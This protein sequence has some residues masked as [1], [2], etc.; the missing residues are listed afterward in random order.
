MLND[1]FFKCHRVLTLWDAC[2]S[3]KK[4]IVCFFFLF[5][6]VCS[7]CFFFLSLWRLLRCKT[8][9][10]SLLFSTVSQKPPAQTI[11]GF[12]AVIVKRFV[13]ETSV[14]VSSSYR[15]SIRVHYAIGFFFIFLKNYF[16]SFARELQLTD[17]LKWAH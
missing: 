15:F 17:T 6:L 13:F 14:A 2:I 10:S 5:F 3:R 4:H 9:N 16:R 8:I 12:I 1:L 11:R 7:V